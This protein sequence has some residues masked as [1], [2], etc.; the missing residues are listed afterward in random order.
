MGDE[1]GPDLT[2]FYSNG[3]APR[4]AP[5][6][7]CVRPLCRDVRAHWRGSAAPG[8]PL[9][10]RPAAASATGGLCSLFC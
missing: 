7:R 10:P 8:A 1:P 4:P 3:P 6:H 9:G 2:K 5:L